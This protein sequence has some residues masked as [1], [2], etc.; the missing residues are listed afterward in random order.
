[1]VL[2]VNIHAAFR[3]GAAFSF[4]LKGQMGQ[5]IQRTDPFRIDVRQCLTDKNSR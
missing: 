3:G 1:M 5:C 2:S 4:L